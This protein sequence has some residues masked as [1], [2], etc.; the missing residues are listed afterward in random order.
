M[1]NLC[2]NLK[3][4]TIKYEINEQQEPILMFYSGKSTAYVLNDETLDKFNDIIS[5]RSNEETDVTQ[6]IQTLITESKHMKTE[7]I[8]LNIKFDR[9]NEEFRSQNRKVDR[10]NEDLGRQNEELSLLKFHFQY[11]T[12]RSFL[13]IV[14]Q[15]H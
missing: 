8:E 3:D 14:Y 5:N 6:S 9:Q 10:H 12:L 15:R 7:L 1:D 2:I 4:K 11:R 13:P